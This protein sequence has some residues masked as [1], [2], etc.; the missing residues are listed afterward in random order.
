MFLL[1]AYGLIGAPAPMDKFPDNAS[2]MIARDE[3]SISVTE[4]DTKFIQ[5]GYTNFPPV[6]FKCIDES[7]KVTVT[8]DK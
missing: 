6:N 1:V 5:Q 2:C 4:S 7:P 8:K 3:L